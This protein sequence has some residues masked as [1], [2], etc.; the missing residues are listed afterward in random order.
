M[1]PSYVAWS[2][3]HLCCYGV[4]VTCAVMAFKRLSCFASVTMKM[5][6]VYIESFLCIA[7]NF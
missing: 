1:F 3:M 5:K 4:I 2:F 6:L 7:M